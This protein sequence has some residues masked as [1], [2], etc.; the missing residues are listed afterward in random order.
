MKKLDKTKTKLILYTYIYDFISHL[1]K[2]VW[3]CLG[4]SAEGKSSV[5][6]VRFGIAQNTFKIIF[7][8]VTGQHDKKKH[9][10]IT[11]KAYRDILYPDID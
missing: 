2:V 5:N 11:R 8:Y 6:N 9:F 4:Y 3:S 1:C 7:L 10:M